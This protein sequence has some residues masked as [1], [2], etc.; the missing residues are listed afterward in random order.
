[1]HDLLYALLDRYQ[2]IYQTHIDSNGQL[3]SFEEPIDKRRRESVVYAFQVM[4]DEHF[5]IAL[6]LYARFPLWAPRTESY[7]KQLAYKLA[8][9][10]IKIEYPGETSIMLKYEV[11]PQGLDY[12]DD[13]D[14]QAD[15]VDSIVLNLANIIFA[16][17]GVV[18]LNCRLKREVYKERRKKLEPD[19]LVELTLCSWKPKSSLLMC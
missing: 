1:M 7:L 11:T 16:V 6:G 10:N 2:N 15:M 3:F 4:D 12:E 5:E 17:R 8:L 13:P 9:D 14:E 19:R 18:H